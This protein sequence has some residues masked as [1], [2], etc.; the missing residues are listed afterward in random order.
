MTSGYYVE[1]YS[2]IKSILPDSSMCRVVF[3]WDVRN[4]LSIAFLPISDRYTTLIFVKNNYKMAA[5]A[6]FGCPKFTFD[7]ISGNFRSIGHFGF[8]K[9]TFDGI[10]G[11]FR[12]IQHFVIFLGG[13]FCC[14]KII[15]DRIS[16]HF[17]SIG[18]FFAC[19]TTG[20]QERQ[21][22]QEI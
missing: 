15:L 21:Y 3:F 17:R 7:H 14:P 2:S 11:H 5:G 20:F 4:S 12:S 8:P 18:F 16:D 9:F 10:S 22:K 1:S 6:H 19:F 13:H